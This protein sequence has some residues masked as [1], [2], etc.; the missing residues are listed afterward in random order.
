MLD[1]STFTLI[2]PLNGNLA[3]KLSTFDSKCQFNEIQRLNYFSLIWIQKGRGTVTA[4]FSENPF[5]AGTLFAFS[6][7]QPFMLAS[8][9]NLEGI[10]I[11]FHPEFFCIYKH[12]AEIACNGILF[13]N[14]FK[15]PYV[16]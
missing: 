6:P 10:V 15:P 2:N 7:Y 16:V 5:E 1:E 14:I 3:F 9:E 8:E 13:N 11:H 12:Q 4:D